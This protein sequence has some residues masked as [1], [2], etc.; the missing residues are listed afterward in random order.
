MKKQNI[1][2]LYKTKTKTIQD[3]NSKMCVFWKKMQRKVSFDKDRKKVENTEIKYH[4]YP[5]LTNM[6][7]VLLNNVCSTND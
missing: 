5:G 1:S 7:N 4:R 2:F 3:P 6:Y